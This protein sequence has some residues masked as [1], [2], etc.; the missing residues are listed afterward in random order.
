MRLSR[1][2]PRTVSSLL[3][4]VRMDVALPYLLILLAASMIAGA[5]LVERRFVDQKSD[6]TTTRLAAAAAQDIAGIF[7]TAPCRQ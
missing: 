6:V 2:S 5:M 1:S 3:S 4:W 7:S